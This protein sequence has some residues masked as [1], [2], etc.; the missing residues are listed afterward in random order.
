MSQKKTIGRVTAIFP[1]GIDV[2]V[3]E[4]TPEESVQFMRNARD[5]RMKQRELRLKMI[6]IILWYFLVWVGCAVF[7]LG[8][9]S[10]LA[11]G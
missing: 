7:G 6:P 5:M 11:G 9:G 10:I 4:S 2:V 8:V 1:D 3:R